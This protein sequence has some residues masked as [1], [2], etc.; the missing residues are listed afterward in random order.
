MSNSCIWPIDRT[1]AGVT[2]Q[3]Q[4]RPGSDCNEGLLR[5]SQSFSI[6]GASPSD[7]LVLHA[8]NSVGLG[9]LVLCRDAVGVFYCPSRLGWLNVRTEV[10]YCCCFCCCCLVGY[11]F[12]F[13][14]FCSFFFFCCCFFFCLMVFGGLFFLAILFCLVM[15]L[16]LFCLLLYF[17]KMKLIANIVSFGLRSSKQYLNSRLE[18]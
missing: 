2:K 1:I 7:S 18:L 10:C 9:V 14:L 13:F 11:F 4:I 15:F 8:G 5:I 3:D 12:L 17:T 6:T 16:F